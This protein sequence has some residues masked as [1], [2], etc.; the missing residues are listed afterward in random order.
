M[1]AP[2][3]H[4]LC[5]I[6][7]DVSTGK[8]T[9]AEFAADLNDVR[10]GAA[11]VVYRDPK[12]F[13][14]RT[15]PTYRMKGLAQQVLI[16]LAGQGGK[17]VLRL[18]VAY[19]GGKTH[20]LITLLH[21]AEQ[22]ETLADHPTVKEF[23]A[24][25]GLAAMPQTR[26]ALLPGD[27]FDVK[28]GLEVF[29]PDGN[30]RRVRTLWGALAYQLAGDVGYAR[31][32]G[33]DQDFI[34][35]AEPLLVDLLKA[36]QQDGR[37]TLILLDEAVWYY[38]ALVNSN[39]RTLGMI[40]DFYQ[41]LTQAVAKVDRAAM[42][43][44]L[45][46]SRIEA[47]DETGT[48][49]LAALDEVFGR[50][51]E[52]VEPVTRDDVAEILR[53]RLFQSVP[54]KEERQ[55]AVDGLMSIL[56]KLP[57]R[58][59]QRDQEMYD[60][61]LESYPFHPDLIN[62]LYQKW[63]Q[64]NN[65][66]RTRGALRLLAYSLRESEGS[67]PNPFVSANALLPYRR[68][69]G[70]QRLSPALNELV[71][72]CDDTHKWMS[73]LTGELDKAR[74]IQATLPTLRHRELEAAVIGV[75]LHSQPAGKHASH[76]ELLALL[77]HPE[78]DPA[79]IEEGLRKWRERSWFLEE[80]PDVWQLGTTPN[81]TH[82][83]FHAKNNVPEPEIQDELR[84]R[85]QAVPTLKA[86]DPGVEVHVLPKSPRDIE[87]DLRLHYL[88]LEPACAITPGQPLSS[89]VEAY[90]NEKSGRRIYRNNIIALAPEA[91][92][93]AGLR[94]QIRNWL[95]WARLEQP[96]NHNLLTDNQ[97]RELPGKKN[98]SVNTLPDMV[99]GAYRILV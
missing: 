18:Q 32:A 22:G 77:A 38:R 78:I 94:D 97:K 11:P 86:A 71:E 43:A 83:H 55:T 29:A 79:A 68:E 44:S 6:R 91:S 41:V 15:Y 17:P 80:N 20:T 19:G 73:A 26:V 28:E 87:D 36:P 27:K 54:G 90:F 5:Q 23:L 81:L 98:A 61:L 58:D 24:F 57:L 7:D 48:Q 8:L 37:S 9:L 45:L 13:F 65:F 3:W 59:S 50:I 39:P 56:H 84:K 31:L 10:T 93:V 92:S 33:H 60:R 49:C 25:A 35:P 99:V 69:N 66:Q 16:R 2:A 74:E 70:K 53:R 4:Q 12:M 40:K 76:M 67:D 34:V 52:P 30:M 95:G 96:A 46:A 63:T 62:V 89:E 88:I 47:N 85:I 72:I 82:M 64:L 51:S 1:T 21:L 14:D 75:F 42:T